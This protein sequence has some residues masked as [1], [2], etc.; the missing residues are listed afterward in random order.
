MNP[1]F[2]I[3]SKNVKLENLVVNRTVGGET[4]AI[5]IQ[6]EPNTQPILKKVKLN[7]KAEN[8]WL[9]NSQIK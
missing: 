5:A 8:V 6:A 9:L 4:G 7:G 1:V 2:I 3:I